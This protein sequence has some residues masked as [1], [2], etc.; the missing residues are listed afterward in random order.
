MLIPPCCRYCGR[1]CNVESPLL[2]LLG[3]VARSAERVLAKP[4]SLASLAGSP[5]RG[6]KSY[7]CPPAHRSKTVMSTEAEPKSKH[8]SNVIS[9]LPRNLFLIFIMLRFLDFTS[10]RSK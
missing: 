3:E 2:S 1:R 8:C 6:A 10:F 4:L 9:S 7:T 5:M